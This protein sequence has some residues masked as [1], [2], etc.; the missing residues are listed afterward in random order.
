MKWGGLK[1]FIFSGSEGRCANETVDKW[2]LSINWLTWCQRVTAWLGA[3]LASSPDPPHPALHAHPVRKN[4]KE[5]LANGLTRRPSR[6]MLGIPG[7]QMYILLTATRVLCMNMMVCCCCRNVITESKERWKIDSNAVKPVVPTLITWWWNL[8][9][10]L[11]Q[12]LPWNKCCSLVG[13]QQRQ[14]W[15]KYLTINSCLPPLLL[16]AWGKQ[17]LLSNFSYGAHVES[18]VRRVC[19]QET[20]G[21][22]FLFLLEMVS[23]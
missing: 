15:H 22:W 19:G 21:K 9:N 4:G 2:F 1:C 23:A 3:Q 17:T 10:K 11:C 6:G 8:T 20:S 13:H 5:G 18:G 7:Q 12:K 16:K 14:Q